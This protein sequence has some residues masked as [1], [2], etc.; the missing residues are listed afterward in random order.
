MF[1]PAFIPPHKG[2]ENVAR[3]NHRLEMTRTACRE[4]PRFEVSDWEIRREGLSYT[5]KTLA[6]FDSSLD[7]DLYF[8]MGTDSLREMRTWKAAERLPALA[9]FLVV[10]R[11]GTE[12]DAAWE[13]LPERIRTEYRREG[14]R[15]VHTS[16][17]ILIP[18]PV[19]G[20]AVSSTRIRDLLKEGRSIRYLVPE[21]VR[22]HIMRNSL[23]G[24]N[25]S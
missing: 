20:L 8:I 10:A 25:Y 9:N 16:S 15:L 11:P 12:F 3:S 5:V 23:Y 1:I 14:D 19:R 13:E 4:N 6:H 17:K 7:G 18:S 22:E 21:A 2:P 24:S